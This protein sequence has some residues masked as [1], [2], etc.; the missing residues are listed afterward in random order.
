MKK[1]T[2]YIL[3]ALGVLAFL[4]AIGLL[5]LSFAGFGM[6]IESRVISAGLALVVFQGGY[7][8][9]RKGRSLIAGEKRKDTFPAD[10]AFAEKS[11]CEGAAEHKEEA[12][13]KAPVSFSAVQSEESGTQPVLEDQLPLDE[14]ITAREYDEVQKKYDEFIKNKELLFISEGLHMPQ[15]YDMDTF[16]CVDQTTGELYLVTREEN[17]GSFRFLLR[18]IGWEE[19]LDLADEKEP[20]IAEDNAGINETNWREYTKTKSTLYLLRRKPYNDK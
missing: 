18:T 15:G 9:C 2:G 13:A 17:M 19:M 16:I 8:A 20:G 5:L 7:A 11:K 6:D 4:G 12:V 14:W 3:C 10:W 1:Q